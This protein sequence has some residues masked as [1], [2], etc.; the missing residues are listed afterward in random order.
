MK[1]YRKVRCLLCGDGTIVTYGNF[2]Q[3]VKA[4]HLPPVICE[5]CQKEFNAVRIVNH[6]RKWHNKIKENNNVVRS[7]DTEDLSLSAPLV[8]S[9]VA[10]VK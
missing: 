8:P 10:S 3:H 9:G 2:G 4:L 7:N 6:K 5:I 1:K